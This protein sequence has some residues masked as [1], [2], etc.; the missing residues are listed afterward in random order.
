[1]MKSDT[2]AIDSR[3]FRTEIES[4]ST[5]IRRICEDLSPS[6]LQNVGLIA[7]LEFLL[8]STIDN[9]HFTASEN[10]E[11]N[12]TFPLNVQLQIYR[13]AQEVLT[14][15]KKHSAAHSVEMKIAAPHNGEFQLTILDDG[16]PFT[17]NGNGH[18][19]GISNIRSRAGLIGA[20]VTWK[21]RGSGG[22]AFS[23]TIAK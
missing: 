11:E 5:E 21:K 17:P 9:R 15:I 10:I 23:M 16:T 2:G 19:R 3:G 8:A 12:I 13:I 6:V 7:A 1:M 4:V 22:T 14:N 20:H 18:G